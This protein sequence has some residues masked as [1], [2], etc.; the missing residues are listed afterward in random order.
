MLMVSKNMSG[1]LRSTLVPVLLSLLSSSVGDK[2]EARREKSPLS[3]LVWERSRCSPWK[4]S[5]LLCPLVVGCWRPLWQPSGA[6]CGWALWVGSPEG[7]REPPIWYLTGKMWPNFTPSVSIQFPPPVLHLSTS[8]CWRTLPFLVTSSHQA[9][10]YN[11]CSVYGTRCYPGTWWECELLPSLALSF[12]SI[13]F[14]IKVRL[15][16]RSSVVPK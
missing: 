9:L 2:E 4:V 13:L 5:L 3:L 11:T 14:L 6:D 8:C 15:S 10:L 7:P 12:H 1:F 16:N